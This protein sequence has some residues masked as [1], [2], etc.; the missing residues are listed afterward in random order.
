MAMKVKL[1]E[2]REETELWDGDDFICSWK[3]LEKPS[4]IG[5]LTAMLQ[6]AYE[7]GGKAR[8]REISILICS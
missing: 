2:T 7:A 5:R 3:G 6:K 4:G 1:N 8:S